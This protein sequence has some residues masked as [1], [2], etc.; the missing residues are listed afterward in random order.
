MDEPKQHHTVADLASNDQTEKVKSPKMLVENGDKEKGE[1][2]DT[3]LTPEISAASSEPE[4]PGPVQ[5]AIIMTC[6]LCA[7]FIMSLVSST[8]FQDFVLR[9]MQLTVS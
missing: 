6:I 8:Y 4:Y 5:V 1:V 2:D 7:I 9:D 3:A